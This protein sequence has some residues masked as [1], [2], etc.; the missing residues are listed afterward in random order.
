MGDERLERFELL[1][2]LDERLTEFERAR[3]PRAAWWRNAPLVVA[4]GGVLALVPALVTGVAGYF[5]NARQYELNKREHEQQQTLEYLRL[6]VDAGAP[7]ATRAQVLRFLVALDPDAPVGTWA[8][9]ELTQVYDKLDKLDVEHASVTKV[10]EELEDEASIAER[11]AAAAEAKAKSDPRE[12]PDAATLVVRARD[13]R[14]DADREREH[15]DSIS[16]RTG[17]APF[18]LSKHRMSL[19][20]EPQAPVVLD[21][22][23]FDRLVRP[24][25]PSAP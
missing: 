19:D 11:D 2:K 15:L 10:V 20:V 4:Y 23:S 6:A 14:R 16:M 25:T 1:L 18:K 5:S 3:P 9:A 22:A 13:L 12:A 24:A 8:R 17:D 21:R 7:E